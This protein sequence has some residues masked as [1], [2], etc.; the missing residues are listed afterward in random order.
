[1]Y[2][3]SHLWKHKNCSKNQLL[4][5]IITLQQIFIQSTAWSSI[6]KIETSDIHA[7]NFSETMGIS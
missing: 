4:Q 6:A 3:K 1:M 5:C 2:V 7:I